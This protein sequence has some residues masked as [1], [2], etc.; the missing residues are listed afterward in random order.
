MLTEPQMRRII[1]NLAAPKCTL[2]L[3]FLNQAMRDPEIY[4]AVRTAAWTV[5]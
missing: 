4:S 5:A 2:Y 1:P 3:P